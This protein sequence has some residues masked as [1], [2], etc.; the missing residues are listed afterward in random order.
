MNRKVWVIAGVALAGVAG[1]SYFLATN[2][3]VSVQSSLK[4]DSGLAAREQVASPQSTAPASAKT[5]DDHKTLAS[6][7]KQKALGT[8]DAAEQRAYWLSAVSEWQA[9]AEIDPTDKITLNELGYGYFYLMNLSSTR[10]EALERFQAG[11]SH[12]NKVLSMDPRFHWSIFGIGMLYFD[13]ADRTGSPVEHLQ[14]A[15][16]YFDRGF[17]YDAN[18]IW[19]HMS[20]GWAYFKIG[21]ETSEREYYRR[22]IPEFE[23]VLMAAPDNQLAKDGIRFAKEKL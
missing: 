9:A 5:L 8:Q 19:G 12:F 2:V 10:T 6:G 13:V 3:S 15:I 7:Y 4:I 23:S 22:A 20:K 21:N 17:E 16:R 1:M 18:Y 11:L 14:E